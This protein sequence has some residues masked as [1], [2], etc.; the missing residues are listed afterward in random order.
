MI[1]KIYKIYK[2]KIYRNYNH[3]RGTWRIKNTFRKIL[4]QKLPKSAEEESIFEREWDNLLILDAC[5]YDLYEEVRGKV[6]KRTS[7]ASRTK[8]YVKET[9]SEGDYSDVVYVTSNPHFHQEQFKELTGRDVDDVFHE[10]FHT[11]ETDWAEEENTVLPEALIRDAETAKKLFPDKK[12]IVHFMQPHYP[13]VKS[14]LTT[15]GIRPDLDHE[16]ED[17]SV[18]Q[19]AEMGDYNDQELWK[20]YKK[21]LEFV[22]EEIQDFAENLEGKTAITSDHGNLVGE[23]GLYGHSF[24]QPAKGLREVPWEKIE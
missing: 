3:L 23:N 2:D 16:K 4:I 11:Y 18:W 19:R 17:F 21:N 24:T 1:Q 5:R 14:N 22:L 9:F 15:K 6:G 20:A 10:V 12:L 8:D 13:F 7:V